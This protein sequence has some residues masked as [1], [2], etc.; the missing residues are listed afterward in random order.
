MN[1]NNYINIGGNNF[2]EKD[3]YNLTY[4]CFICINDWNYPP[5]VHILT[6]D[7]AALIHRQKKAAS[8]IENV[9][10]IL[11]ILAQE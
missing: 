5:L 10:V 6:M 4:Y 2:Y 1:Y 7:N 11:V 8:T 9:M 3:Y